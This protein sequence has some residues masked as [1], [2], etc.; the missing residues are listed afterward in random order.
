M[1]PPLAQVDESAIAGVYRGTV[2]RGESD[3]PHGDVRVTDCHEAVIYLLAPLQ[4][5]EGRRRGVTFMIVKKGGFARIGTEKCSEINS[6]R[7]GVTFM[8]I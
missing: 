7:K 8:I 2:V 4:V 3:L 6:R 5:E 1:Q